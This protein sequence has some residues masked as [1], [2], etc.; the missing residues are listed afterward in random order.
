MILYATKQTTERY[1]LKMPNELS[2]TLLQVIYLKSI[3][4]IKI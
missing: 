3:K 2:D 4:M 1:N